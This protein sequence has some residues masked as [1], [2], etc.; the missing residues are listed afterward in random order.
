MGGSRPGR[1]GLTRC[2]GQ[3]CPELT[4]ETAPCDVEPDPPVATMH[5]ARRP[6]PV[7]PPFGPTRR[8]PWWRIWGEGSGGRDVAVGI[9]RTASYDAYPMA[10]SLAPSAPRTGLRGMVNAADHLAATAGVGLLQ[11]GGSAAD[12]A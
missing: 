7:V 6:D 2:H 4:P 3:R 5:L 11:Q 1:P 12:A 8:L 9:G 10:Y